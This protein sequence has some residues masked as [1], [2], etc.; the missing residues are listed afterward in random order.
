[1]HNTDASQ[2]SIGQMVTAPRGNNGEED[3]TPIKDLKP[4]GYVEP[5]KYVSNIRVNS[6][7]QEKSNGG[8]IRLT[9]PTFQHAGI[10][11]GWSVGD[12]NHNGQIDLDDCDIIKAIYFTANNAISN[13]PDLSL[14]PKLKP[15]VDQF[16]TDLVL[17]VA[18]VDKDDAVNGPDSMDY[19]LLKRAYAG[20]YDYVPTNV[21]GNNQPNNSYKI[22]KAT[23]NGVYVDI[24]IEGNVL[25]SDEGIIVIRG[26]GLE[27][28]K[29]EFIPGNQR[30]AK[31]R[32]TR[33]VCA[34]QDTHVLIIRHT[35]ISI[36]D[37]SE[38]I[39]VI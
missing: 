21:L 30:K 33:P 2:G 20:T 3:L 10:L 14:V 36:K 37:D 38:R 8:E 34:V 4:I 19:I 22:W 31:I 9:V 29:V 13:T 7:T 28:A 5:G 6:H 32:V 39:I 16:G 35:G 25:G 12:L 27:E 24:D 18:D 1:M 11:A 26:V 23:K 17:K 15:L